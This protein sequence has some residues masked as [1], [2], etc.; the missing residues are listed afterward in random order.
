M[1][2]VILLLIFG[3]EFLAFGI[4]NKKNHSEEGYGGASSGSIIIDSIWGLFAG[5]VNR[6]P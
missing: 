2:E 5:I 6:L 3:I 4:R 1:W